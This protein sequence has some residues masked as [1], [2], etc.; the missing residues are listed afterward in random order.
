MKFFK[1]LK[2][3]F[4]GDNVETGEAT[5]ANG[6][7]VEHIVIEGTTYTRLFSEIDE[8]S[9]NVDGFTEYESSYRFTHGVQL[10]GAM[11][12]ITVSSVEK[13]GSIVITSWNVTENGYLSMN[14]S[15]PNVGTFLG[16]ITIIATSTGKAIENG[17]L[18][19]KS[20][21]KEI[22]LTYEFAV[23]TLLEADVIYFNS[24]GSLSAVEQATHDS[25]LLY[26]SKF[27]NV[28]EH[29]SNGTVSSA[30]SV[31]QD[32]Y[33]EH[34]NICTILVGEK[35]DAEFIQNIG[36]L[37][38]GEGNISLWI[39]DILPAVLEQNS[40]SG[41][42]FGTGLIPRSADFCENIPT[43]AFR[44]GE[45][46]LLGVE[47]D[48][49]GALVVP[50]DLINVISSSGWTYLSSIS[51]VDYMTD[52]NDVNGAK[53]FVKEVVSQHG[54]AVAIFAMTASL[55]IAAGETLQDSGYN[56]TSGR[57]DD[58]VMLFCLENGVFYQNIVDDIQGG[59]GETYGI[60]GISYQGINDNLLDDIVISSNI[61]GFPDDVTNN[62][63]QDDDERYLPFNAY[64][65][66]FVGELYQ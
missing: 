41:T 48:S 54:T 28:R 33:E 43:N 21:T 23:L 17:Q 2:V 12:N 60:M 37:G 34:N 46:V 45:F 39:N 7:L 35:F 30:I 40:V 36:G 62:L 8:L 42:I 32:A 50:Q 26:L 22:T 11:G 59:Q 1:S 4:L 5:T 61:G 14:F 9:A 10:K 3:N 13:T 52:E 49:N 66:I 38:I 56:E 31:Y 47:R 18:V 65:H 27:E 53:S 15:A 44:G 58:C 64:D 19:E 55:A 51:P 20:V 29:Y 57:L 63:P 24:Q 16:T 6:K 25:V